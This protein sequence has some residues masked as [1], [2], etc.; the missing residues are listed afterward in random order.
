[1]RASLPRPRVAVELEEV[2]PLLG[3]LDELYPHRGRSIRGTAGAC[4]CSSENTAGPSCVASSAARPPPGTAPPGWARRLRRARGLH[5]VVPPVGLPRLEDGPPCATRTRVEP[6]EHLGRDAVV[7]LHLQHE[8]RV[9]LRGAAR[10]LGGEGLVGV[11]RGLGVLSPR[12]SR[13]GRAGARRG[14][15][16]ARRPVER[17]R[18]AVHTSREAGRTRSSHGQHGRLAS[19]I[20][21]ARPAPTPRRDHRPRPWQ[22]RPDTSAIRASWPA[23]S[24][25]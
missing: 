3:H 12:P 4:W 6:T 22:A 1:M 14:R 10:R 21:E 25:T 19:M 23:R 16:C 2:R 7:D 13:A 24:T 8:P 18:L 17:V 15:R 5:L 11:N 20:V 9:A